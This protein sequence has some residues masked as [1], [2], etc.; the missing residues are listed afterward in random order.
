MRSLYEF[1]FWFNF[2][3]FMLRV[4]VMA[5][6]EVK[7]LYLQFFLLFI[8][9]WVSRMGVSD[10]VRNSNSD[11]YLVCCLVLWYCFGFFIGNYVLNFPLS[12]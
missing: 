10:T 3:L 12:V 1:F 6:T 9:I 7:T 2:R 5:L 8:L 11:L 4:W